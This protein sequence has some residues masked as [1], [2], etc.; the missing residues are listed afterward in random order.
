VD[1]DTTGPNPNVNWGTGKLLV[2]PGAYSIAP[3]HSG[4]AGTSTTICGVDF[5]SGM[6][7]A[8]TPLGST[9]PTALATTATADPHC[10]MVTMPASSTA[11]IVPLTFTNPDNSTGADTFT[12][13]PTPSSYQSVA[14]FRVL[15][16]RS[17]YHTGTCTDSNGTS[18][19]CSTLGA[20]Q[21]LNVL[22]TGVTG[23]GV[24]ASGVSAVVLNVTAADETVPGFFTVWPTGVARP[25][26]SNLNF[27]AG[28]VVP[29]LVE[30][31]VGAGGQVSLYNLA[32]TADAVFDIAGYVP[33]GNTGPAGL[34][35]GIVPFRLLDT[36]ARFLTGSC[37]VTGTSTATPC[38]TLGSGQSIDL[39]VTG[40][41]NSGIPATGVMAVALNVTVTNATASSFLTAYPAG[42]TRPLASNLNFTPGLTVPNRVMVQIGVVNGVGRITLFNFAGTVD[43]VVDGNGWFSDGV[44]QTTG[45]LYSGITPSRIVDTRFSRVIGSGQSLTVQVAGRGGIPAMNAATPPTAVV[46]NVAVADTTFSSFL[47][48]YPSDASRPLASDLNWTAGKVVANLVIV[49]LSATGQVTFFNFAG[50]TDMVVDVEGWYT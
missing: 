20:Q 18:V 35:N 36:R 34:F 12:Y 32:G 4:L 25:L 7:I 28:Q 31:P 37:F 50:V 29:N 43:V 5:Q 47:T 11:G 16:T 22:V 3:S 1:S 19:T 23:S 44:S 15:D 26:A 45:G 27:V 30:V 33:S 17:Q 21:T 41:T 2:G 13:D 24:P 46:L 42:G 40:V 49:K 48:A 8:F 39:Q 10:L 38:G 14:P 9:T 6:A